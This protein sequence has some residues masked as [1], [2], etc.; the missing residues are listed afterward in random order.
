MKPNHSCLEGNAKEL[1][2]SSTNSKA[3]KLFDLIQSDVA[4]LYR[5]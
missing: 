5:F 2:L 4:S 3:S 1:H